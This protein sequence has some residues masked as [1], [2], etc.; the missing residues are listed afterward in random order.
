MFLPAAPRKSPITAMS[1][2]KI[3]DGARRGAIDRQRSRRPAG[4]RGARRN[5]H[6][7]PAALDRRLGR[8]RRRGNGVGGRRAG[9]EPRLERG[10]PSRRTESR[11]ASNS[12][13]S[14]SSSSRSLLR[15]RPAASWLATGSSGR[16]LCRMDSGRGPVQRPEHYRAAR[17]RHTSARARSNPRVAITVT[18]NPIGYRCTTPVAGCT[19]QISGVRRDQPMTEGRGPRG[20][21]GSA[22]GGHGRGEADGRPGVEQPRIAL[23]GPDPAA[24][25]A[26]D[27]VV[28][29]V[30]CVVDLR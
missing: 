25:S 11:I 17:R 15:R 5:L 6:G 30:Q 14:R 12:L 27:P 16:C 2:L 26:D 18:S 7:R 1:G 24:A 22:G 20:R 21:E 29:V 4:A 3:F 28:Q 19:G 13:R 23:T 9:T 8:P 10:E